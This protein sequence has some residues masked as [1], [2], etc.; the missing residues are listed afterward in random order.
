MRFS[1]ECRLRKSSEFIRLRRAGK[2]VPGRYFHLQVCEREDSVLPSRLGLAVSRRIGPAVTR[3]LVKRRFREIF[4]AITPEFS[5][6]IDLVV[7]ARKG[8]DRVPF[9][10]LKQQFAHA[11]RAWRNESHLRVNG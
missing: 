5:G 7:I 1:R 10:E 9:S 2:W 6:P 8:V 4:R 3:N 11:L